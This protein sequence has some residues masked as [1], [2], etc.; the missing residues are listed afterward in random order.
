MVGSVGLE[1]A[2]EWDPGRIPG[3]AGRLATTS[4]G[5]RTG[6]RRALPHDTTHVARPDDCVGVRSDDLAAIDRSIDVT[7]PRLRADTGIGADSPTI[8]RAAARGRRHRRRP[9]DRSIDPTIDRL[10]NVTCPWLRADVGTGAD[11]PS[12]E[13]IRQLMDRSMWRDRG[14]TR[15]SESTPTERSTD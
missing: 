3:M 2:E 6:L 1:M 11:H 15:I 5:R 12:D 10:I 4:I 14:H 8:A 9:S 7:R 13:T